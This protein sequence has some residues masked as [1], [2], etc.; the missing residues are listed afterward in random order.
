MNSART[1]RYMP[2]QPVSPGSA[3]RFH[4]APDHRREGEDQQD[5]GDGLE[6][7]VE[8]LQQVADLAAEE[9][10]TGAQQVPISV[11]TSAA[12][13]PTKTEISVPLMA[14]ASTSRPRRSPPKGSVSALTVS[15]VWNWLGALVPLLVARRQRV[16]VGQVDVGALGHLDRAGGL[17]RRGPMKVG[18]ALGTPTSSCQWLATRPAGGQRDQQQESSTTTSDARPTRSALKRRQAACQTPSDRKRRQRCQTPRCA[19][20]GRRGKSMAALI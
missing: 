3:P 10:P 9:A 5:V 11:A 6:D 20:S 14:L 8:P 12:I 4:A 16:D 19:R 1:W 18:G 17:G 7:V 13:T 2:V 15:S